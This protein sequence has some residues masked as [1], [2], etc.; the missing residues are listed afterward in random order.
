MTFLQ[1]AKMNNVDPLPWLTQTLKC[2]VNGWP[3]SDLK[4]LMP[5]HYGQ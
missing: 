1:T 3:S 4:A 2:I 5:R